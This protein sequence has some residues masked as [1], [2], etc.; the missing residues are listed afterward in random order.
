MRVLGYTILRT[1][2]HD[3]FVKL[4]QTTANA[5]RVMLDDV[6]NLK[7]RL[8]SAHRTIDQQQLDIEALKD[9]CSRVNVSALENEIRRLNEEK[10]LP[11]HVVREVDKQPDG[12]LLSTL[13]RVASSGEAG[14][15][16]VVQDEGDGLPEAH[17]ELQNGS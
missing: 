15:F 17:K 1:S 16:G 8:S 13:V 7:E 3:E 2:R 11:G 10:N 9:K 4:H 12:F 14:Y 6:R 5:N